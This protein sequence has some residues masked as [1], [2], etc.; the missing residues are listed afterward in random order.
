MLLSKLHVSELHLYLVIS[1]KRNFH[2]P[3]SSDAYI[4]ASEEPS[5]IY[6]L[7]AL[8]PIHCYIIIIYIKFETYTNISSFK[9]LNQ[10]LPAILNKH[11]HHI[12]YMGITRKVSSSPHSNK[13]CFNR[14][15]AHYLFFLPEPTRIII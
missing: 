13:K 5:N 14:M 15:S 9:D 8:K 1:Y 11:Y 4:N 6:D 3:H 2:I 12:V 10:L 7:Y